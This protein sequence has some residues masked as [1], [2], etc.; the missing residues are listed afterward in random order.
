MLLKLAF[1]CNYSSE[2]QYF[3]YTRY[4]FRMYFYCISTVFQSISKY[5]N[6]ISIVS[7]SI[8]KYYKFSKA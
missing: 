4:Q 7:Q 5:F 6:R 1:L 2:Y 3:I 8:S